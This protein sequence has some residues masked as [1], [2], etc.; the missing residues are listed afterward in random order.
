[1]FGDCEVCSDGRPFSFNK[2]RREGSRVTLIGGFFVN[3]C[4]ECSDA[5]HAFVKASPEF[6]QHL[7]IVKRQKQHRARTLT[8][9]R[10]EKESDLLVR[11]AGIICDDDEANQEALYALGKRWVTERRAEFAKKS[12]AEAEVKTKAETETAS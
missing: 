5:W 4:S 12:E 2:A 11:A 8:M 10:D 6:K 9:P 3:M 7:D 1:V